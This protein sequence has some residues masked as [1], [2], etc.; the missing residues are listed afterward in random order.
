MQ[1]RPH[2]WLPATPLWNQIRPVNEEIKRLAFLWTAPGGDYWVSD[3]RRTLFLERLTDRGRVRLAVN[4]S[5]DPVEIKPPLPDGFS[6]ARDLISQKPVPAADGAITDRIDAL[7][8][9]A[10]QFEP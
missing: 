4:R 5:L 8:V 2:F 7:D 3:D 6:K 1:P 9:R 10:Y